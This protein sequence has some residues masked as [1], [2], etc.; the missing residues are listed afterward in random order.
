MNTENVSVGPNS[1]RK[2]WINRHPILTI[3]GLLI[4]ISPLISALGGGSSSSTTTPSSVASNDTSSPKIGDIGYVKSPNGSP[5]FVSSTK[6]VEDRVAQLSV[7]KDTQGLMQMVLSGDPLLVDDGTQVRIIGASFT[8]YEVRITNGKFSGQSGWIPSEFVSAIAPSVVIQSTPTKIKTTTPPVAKTSVAVSKSVPETTSPSKPSVYCSTASDCAGF[9]VK[10]DF[11]EDPS[12][13]QTDNPNFPCKY[14][15]LNSSKKIYYLT[16][17]GDT[18]T[19]EIKLKNLNNGT[20]ESY[21]GSD[22]DLSGTYNETTG[23]ITFEYHYFEYPNIMQGDVSETHTGHITGNQFSG[24]Y[25]YFSEEADVLNKSNVVGDI[26]YLP[27][28]ISDKI[29]KKGCTIKADT[30]SVSGGTA[31]YYLTTNSSYSKITNPD[32]WFCSESDAVVAGYQ[33]ALQ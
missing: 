18:V 27:I 28:N 20:E 33:K 10:I 11:Q 26:T 4:L 17:R 29:P 14:Y 8:L 3:I 19:G 22:S 9:K 21:M 5:S 13:S 16:V 12:C 6:D 32:D 31:T 24:V 7:A 15:W 2:N 30:Y 25:Q 23:E 1:P